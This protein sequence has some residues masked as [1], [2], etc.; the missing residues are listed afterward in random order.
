MTS[1][2]ILLIV[3]L[4]AA[5]FGAA[6]HAQ[7]GFT[8]GGDIGVTNAPGHGRSYDFGLDA[9]YRLDSVLGLELSYASLTHYETT[10]VGA[11]AIVHHPIASRLHLL[12][13]FGLVFWTESPTGY[14]GSGEAPLLGVGLSY[15]LAPASSARVEYQ[16]VPGASGRLGANLDTLIVGLQQR[17]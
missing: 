4:A 2:Q 7:S 11:S 16:L 15:A 1:K 13:Q 10:L 3:L 12:G 8:V 5:P 17:F 6:A 14:D 9:G